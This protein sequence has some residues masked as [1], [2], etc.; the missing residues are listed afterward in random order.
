M[1]TVVMG[2][3]PLY[4]LLSLSLSLSLPG[5]FI[6]WMHL[7]RFIQRVETNMWLKFC[8]CIILL[9]QKHKIQYDYLT[10]LGSSRK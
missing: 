9:L 4:L 10:V 3:A 5:L 6:R 7:W 1:E 8:V 2:T